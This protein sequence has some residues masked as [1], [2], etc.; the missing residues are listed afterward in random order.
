MIAHTTIVFMRYIFFALASRN[1]QDPRTIGDLFY[2]ECDELENIRF[3]KSLSLL[4]H[5]LKELL[6]GEFVLSEQQVTKVLDQLIET[7]PTSFKEILSGNQ[8][9]Q[10]Y[11]TV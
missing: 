4:L 10:A 11:S 5:A 9:N 6:E 1:E 7:L 2:M 8:P 3:T